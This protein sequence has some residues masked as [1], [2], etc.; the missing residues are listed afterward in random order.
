MLILSRRLGESIHLGDDIVISILGIRGKQ[1]KVGIE[2]PDD[3]PV[4][5]EEVFKR[6]QQE[7]EMAVRTCTQDLVAAANI[8]TRKNKER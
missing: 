3:I 2:V 1:V 7:N 4:Y 5:R 8:W 6:I